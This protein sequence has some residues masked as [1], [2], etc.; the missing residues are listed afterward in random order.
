MKAW[1]NIFLKRIW[2][3]FKT[4]ILKILYSPVYKHRVKKPI[5]RNKIVFVEVRADKLTD[6]FELLYKEFKAKG[7]EI[8]VHYIRNTFVGLWEY[9]KRCNSMLHDISDARFVFLN[10]ASDVLGAIPLRHE[11]KIIQVWHGCG[12]F[13]KFGFSTLGIKA[14][15]Y[16]NTSLVS[17]SSPEVIWAYLEAM[18]LKE[19]PDKVKALGVSRTDVYFDENFKENAYKKFYEYYP[20]A[21]NKKIILYAPT[22]RGNISAGYLNKNIDMKKMRGRLSKEYILL[23][24]FHPLAREIDSFIDT[25]FAKDVTK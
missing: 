16:N 1:I 11:T 15:T 2:V 21:K 3:I 12:A 8:K 23:C 18:N 13:K 4:I 5:N 17:V 9:Y 6:N 22:F 25:S 20:E 7:Y 10:E 19:T 14:I 24:K